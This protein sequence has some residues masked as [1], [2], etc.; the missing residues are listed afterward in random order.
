MKRIQLSKNIEN[1]AKAILYR[2]K[3]APGASGLLAR[4]QKEGIKG[5]YIKEYDDCNLDG[6]IVKGNIINVWKYDK[7]GVEELEKLPDVKPYDG[8]SSP[9]P[10]VSFCRLE[11]GEEMVLF[12]YF[13]PRAARG[14][15]CR[16]E[17]VYNYPTLVISGT[18]M[19]VS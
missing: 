13:G 7:N 2:K 4:I 10:Q 3:D 5:V 12:A 1:V 14:F 6:P 19:F 18:N 16:P 11:N 8:I 15:L 17:E 9:F